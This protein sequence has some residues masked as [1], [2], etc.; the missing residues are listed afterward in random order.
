MTNLKCGF[1]PG[2]STGLDAKYLFGMCGTSLYRLTVCATS[3]GRLL[4]GEALRIYR[5]EYISITSTVLLLQH[6]FHCLLQ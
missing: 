4:L 5:Y 2:T 6:N 3:V 1:S